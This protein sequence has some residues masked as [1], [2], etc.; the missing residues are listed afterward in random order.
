M[1]LLRLF[2]CFFPP[3]SPFGGSVKRR[4]FLQEEQI[5]TVVDFVAAATF[6]LKESLKYIKESTNSLISG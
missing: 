2:Y 3:Q 6:D 5:N 1:I 4:V